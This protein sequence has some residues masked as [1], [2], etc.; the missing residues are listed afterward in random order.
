M[1]QVSRN[2][3]ALPL[4]LQ[5][6]PPS[7]TR[8]LPTT[9][10]SLR[11]RARAEPSVLRLVPVIVPDARCVRVGGN[12][13]GLGLSANGKKRDGSKFGAQARALERKSKEDRPGRHC[14]FGRLV[15]AAWN[16]GGNEDGVDLMQTSILNIPWELNIPCTAQFTK[17]PIVCF[18]N[19]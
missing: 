4:S 3:H 2:P 6:A 11:A 10:C 17:I 14:K 19:C 5:P 7:P 1:K 16:R 9:R 13:I 18:R 12:G 15:R 8:R